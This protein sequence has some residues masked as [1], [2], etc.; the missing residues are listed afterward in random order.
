M[1][2][3]C[4]ARLRLNTPDSSQRIITS[5][6]ILYLFPTAFSHSQ[7]A[8]LENTAGIANV[9]G[10][11]TTRRV[12]TTQVPKLHLVE[13]GEALIELNI[14]PSIPGSQQSLPIIC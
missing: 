6:T 4:C 11:S 8:T 2:Q 14:S 12:E 10:P 5:E 7:V 13:L 9:D 3:L 1:F